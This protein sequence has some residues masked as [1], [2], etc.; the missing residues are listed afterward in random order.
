MVIVPDIRT[1]EAQS[2]ISKGCVIAE[3][4]RLLK[5][6]R[7][8]HFSRQSLHTIH[9][10]RPKAGTDFIIRA[11]QGKNRIMARVID[12]VT[13]LVSREHHQEIKTI[14]GCITAD[15]AN[16]LIKVAAIDRRHGMDN[17]FVG[18]L[19]GYGLKAGAVACSAAWDSAD[20]IA[21]GADDDDLAVAVNRIHE[22]QGG[23]LVCLREK[24]VAELPLPVFGILSPLP[25]ASIAKKVKAISEEITRL[26]CP[27]NDPLLTLQVLTGAAIPFLRI[28][29]EGL[30]NLKDGLTKG[31]F[32]D[33]NEF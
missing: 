6:A 3:Q 31:L 4:G 19:K 27:F 2:V 23:M 21:V 26:G 12:M 28:C 32:L 30:V 24:I 25:L 7:H 18:L 1:I 22:I 9:L 8:H 10:P 33:D 13:D 17:T 14:D 11:P 20:I 16:D 15:P 29:E 5:P